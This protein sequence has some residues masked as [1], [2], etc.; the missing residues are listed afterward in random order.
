MSGIFSRPLDLWVAA[1]VQ[2]GPW[3]SPL[4]ISGVEFMQVHSVGQ[5]DCKA[6][7]GV[8]PGATASSVPI[9]PLGCTGLVEHKSSVSKPR[10][11]AL[12]AQSSHQGP[13]QTSGELNP[14][15][16]CTGPDADLGPG[17]PVAAKAFF[18]RALS[19]ETENFLINAENR[20]RQEA[21]YPHPPT[22]CK[23]YLTANP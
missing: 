5:R 16:P 14:H 3:V 2:G 20:A 19:W 6:P 11:L 12:P 9:C 23:P 18:N 8:S 7:A 21:H 10:A 15:F 22:T 1:Q 17:T 4:M 13:P